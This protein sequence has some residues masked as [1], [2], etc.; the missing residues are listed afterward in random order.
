MQES[1]KHLKSPS[2]EWNNSGTEKVVLNFKNY[3]YQF[4]N[5]NDLLFKIRIWI[6]AQKKLIIIMKQK[7][8]QL[9]ILQ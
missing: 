4:L 3:R 9:Q 8:W 6:Q 5:S 7:I 1:L 2:V